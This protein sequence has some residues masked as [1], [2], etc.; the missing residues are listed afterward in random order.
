MSPVENGNQAAI[1]KLTA[2]V[3]TMM[4]SRDRRLLTSMEK[5]VEMQIAR[6][7]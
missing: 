5:V 7:K 4:E 2:L 1:L 3:E 6:E